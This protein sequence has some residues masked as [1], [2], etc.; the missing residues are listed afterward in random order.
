MNHDFRF[1]GIQRLFGSRL[2]KSLN[3]SHVS[4][5]GIGGVGS[6]AAEALA[7]SGLGQISLIDSMN[8]VEQLSLNEEEP[9]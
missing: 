8:H 6:W 7:R 3:E 9:K 5:V 1:G 4:I 2:F